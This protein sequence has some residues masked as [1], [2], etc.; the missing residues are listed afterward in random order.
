[1]TKSYKQIT[2]LEICS[3][4]KRQIPEMRPSLKPIH[5][6]TQQC[7]YNPKALLQ[8]SGIQVVLPL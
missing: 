5:F 4:S 2:V 3:Q 8:G 7:I 1:M 6:N